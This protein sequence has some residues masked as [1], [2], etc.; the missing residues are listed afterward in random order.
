M[1]D[2]T[3]GLL[4]KGALWQVSFGKRHNSLNKVFFSTAQ[5]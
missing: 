1:N 5:K 4:K 2:E 3:K